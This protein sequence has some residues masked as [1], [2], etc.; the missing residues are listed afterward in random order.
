MGAT[1]TVVMLGLRGQL[2]W[3]N[4]TRASLRARAVTQTQHRCGALSRQHAAG[5]SIWESNCREVSG[6]TPPALGMELTSTVQ[7]QLSDS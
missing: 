3:G 7:V 2:S 6:Q 5:D 4:G 1:Y